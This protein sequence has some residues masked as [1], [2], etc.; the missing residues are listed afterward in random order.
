MP[1]P[2]PRWLSGDACCYSVFGE[3]RLCTC[4][5]DGYVTCCWCCRLIRQLT[6][7]KEEK[8]KQQRVNEREEWTWLENGTLRET[9]KFLCMPNWKK[10][11]QTSLQI[12]VWMGN[13]GFLEN[14]AIFPALPAFFSLLLEAQSLPRGYWDIWVSLV[15]KK[16]V[17]ISWQC[18][19]K[20]TRVDS[21]YCTESSW[22]LTCSSRAEQEA[23]EHFFFTQ[24]LHIL[25][26][27][28]DSFANL[29]LQH[30]SWLL[31]LFSRTWVGGHMI[32]GTRVSLMPQSPHVSL[33]PMH[34]F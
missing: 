7:F 12:Q 5:G 18:K 28:L 15:P 6:C 14:G 25:T 3:E 23:T 24:N 19:M 10:G 1:C 31:S 11:N 34:I 20:E 8:N 17:P 21:F 33:C 9:H 13:V 30:P 22:M 26:L 4:E 16:C 27:A 2:L 29:G 32:S